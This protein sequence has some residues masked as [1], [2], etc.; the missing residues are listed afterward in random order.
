MT[1][2]HQSQ[3][4]SGYESNATG[5]I[6]PGQRDAL[7][8]SNDRSMLMG[9]VLI[10]VFTVLASGG[11]YI[12]LTALGEPLMIDGELN[13]TFSCIAFGGF[14]MGVIGGFLIADNWN[15]R[16]SAALADA[17]MARPIHQA[18]ASIEWHRNRF[19]ARI[20]NRWYPSIY[21]V[22]EGGRQFMPGIYRVHYVENPNW[23]L[24]AI[25]IPAGVQSSENDDALLQSLARM[26]NLLLGALPLNR[27]GWMGLLQR[28]RLLPLLVGSGWALLT[29]LIPVLMFVI[30]AGLF[31]ASQDFRALI[32]EEPATIIPTELP[33]ASN[34]S[35]YTPLLIGLFFFIVV[36]AYLLMAFRQGARILWLLLCLIIGRAA[37]IE[38]ELGRYKIEV[39]DPDDPDGDIVHYY[40]YYRVHGRYFSIP[41]RAYES[42]PEGLDC[43]VYYV[44]AKPPKTYIGHGMTDIMDN[45]YP[46]LNIE[47]LRRAAGGGDTTGSDRA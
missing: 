35:D 36:L 32:G 11:G 30:F 31:A 23:L 20:N 42:T 9:L 21:N 17:V 10:L 29:L 41:R 14:L 5:R 25:P 40:Y 37:Q 39:G 46:M 8:A 47:P 16:R 27:L 4:Q 19:K 2:D 24:S 28:V 38:G 34:L 18:Q 33:Q 7:I 3:L 22:G 1:T 6:T 13:P 43:R 15:K 45:V 12:V 44:P 26:N